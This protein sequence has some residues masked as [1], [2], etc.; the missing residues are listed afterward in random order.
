MA[1]GTLLLAAASA[2]SLLQPW[3]LKLVLDSVLGERGSSPLLAR[4]TDD[5]V[6]RVP[7]VGD[8]RVV[9]LLILCAGVLLVQLLMG[10]LNVLSTYVLVSIG[11]RMVFRLRCALFDRVQQMSLSFHDSRPVGDSLYRVTWDTYCVQTLFNSGLVPAVTAV[12]TL[13]GISAVMV[14]MDWS[15]TVAALAIGLPLVVLIRRLDRPTTERSLRVHERESDVSSLVQETLSAIRAVQAFG[16]ERFEAARFRRQAHESL[17]ANLRLTVLQVA[18]Q[19]IVGVLLAAGTAGV[20]WLAA[21]R[22]L[23]GYLTAGDVVLLTA[24]V[25]MLYKPLET[26]SYT[27]AIVQGAAAGGRRV[28]E[29]LDALPEVREKSEATALVGRAHGHL[30][31]EHVSFA[32]TPAQPVLRDVSLDIPVGTTVAIV[33]ASGAGKTTLASLLLRFYDP[34]GGRIT[35][36]GRDL[37][38]LT[39]ES[40]RR[41][42]ALVLQE[43]VLFS[44]TIRENIAYGRPDATIA[45]IEQAARAAGAHAF[46]DALPDRYDTKIG[47]RGV[48]LSGGQ[49]QRIAIARAF[50]K[51]APILVMDEPTSALDVETEAY[52][53]TS[54]AEL[55][56]GRTTIVIAH[57]L[58]TIRNADQVVVLDAG[59]KVQ[60]GTHAELATQPGAFRRLREAAVV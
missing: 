21:T 55:S 8:Q 46:V 60:E 2:A 24:Y 59:R 42:V 45:E 43:P 7:F 23:A 15:I 11:L 9:L 33:G 25:A 54:L 52:L 4:A 47:E 26:L 34:T 17:R 14:A 12:I 48:A 27:A 29:I 28:F 36:D 37:R 32:Y 18:S 38:D 41:N 56:R 6:A 10:I 39:L 50:L 19:A 58:S 44:A 20:V 40:L 3:P 1:L 31:F 53:L 13:A 49:R 5:V 16:R 35:L 51:D 30:V 57:R 22:A